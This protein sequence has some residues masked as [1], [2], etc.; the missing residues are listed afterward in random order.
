L[1]SGKTHIYKR[2]DIFVIVTFGVISVNLE[3]VQDLNGLANERDRDHIV[4]FH[5]ILADV[6]LIVSS[7]F[8]KMMENKCQLCDQMF[9]KR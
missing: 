7:S 8:S 6:S 3:S 9:R 1:D 5:V 2:F 4:F